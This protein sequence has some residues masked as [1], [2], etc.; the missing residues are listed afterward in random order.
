MTVAEMFAHI[1][2]DLLGN[3]TSSLGSENWR[4]QRVRAFKEFQRRNL[5][6]IQKYPVSAEIAEELKRTYRRAGLSEKQALRAALGTAKSPGLR[7]AV[8]DVRINSLIQE[9]DGLFRDVKI[10]ALRQADDIYRKTLQKA[11]LAMSTNLYTLNQ[12]IDMGS[13]D[14]L[15]AGINCVQYADGRLMNIVSYVE[16][17]MRSATRR[18][19]I[20]AEGA[21]RAE[22]GIYTV[23]S[24]QYGAC[25]KTCLP[26]QGKVYWDDVFGG[27]NPNDAGKY[28]LLST[29]IKAGL[30]HPNCRHRLST[31][32]PGVNTVPEP[33]D[34]ERVKKASALEAEQRYNE[35]QIRKWKRMEQGSLDPENRAKY[36]AKVKQ[37]QQRQRELIN[38]NRDILRR[39][40]PREQ[41]RDFKIN[42]APLTGTTQSGIIGAGGG[43]M[44]VLP[45]SSS[46]YI[47][48]EKF[49]NYALNPAREPN[50]ALAFK[51]ALGYDLT[52]TA[53]LVKNIKTNVGNFNAVEKPDNGY[54]K[55]FEVLMTLTGANGKKA[56]VKTAWI[57]DAKTG[58][59]RLV[60][61]YV[62]KK[63]FKG[64]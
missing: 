53:E 5:K 31:F 64:G 18:A 7:Y 44:N 62:T 2:A 9:I 40:Y 15:S 14:F 29:A 46:A 16:M 47:P 58:E 22:W 11:N 28:P 19:T 59:T 36:G 38:A 23:I 6:L 30:L 37:W 34:E 54:G 51:D 48:V 10:A 12:G 45:N 39:D 1:E 26:W 17:A 8:S 43:T 57:L 55:R 63:Q 13:R 56:N 24:S 35:R 25:S 41:V 49:D 3:V 32:F 61:A 4:M 60:S 50:K 20:H 42:G 52:N 27:G 21:E 33:L